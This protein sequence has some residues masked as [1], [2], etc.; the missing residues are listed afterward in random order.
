MS[1]EK[2]GE[3]QKKPDGAQDNS[4]SSSEQNAAGD[5][6][7]GVPSA[8]DLATS[9]PVQP[10]QSNDTSNSGASGASPPAS[11]TGSANAGSTN[12]SAP[13]NASTSASPSTPVN[14]E[15]DD[16]YVPPPPTYADLAARNLPAVIKDANNTTQANQSSTNQTGSSGSSGPSTIPA[17]SGIPGGVP[18]GVKQDKFAVDEVVSFGWKAMLKYFWPLTGVFTC[19]FMVQMVPTVTTLVLKYCVAQTAAISLVSAVVSLL[20]AVVSLIMSVGVINMWLKIVDGDSIAVRDVYSKW[21]RTWNFMLAS[22]VYGV[23]VIAG[24]IC[25]IIPGIYLQ[26][27]FQFYPFFIVESNAGPITSL[28]ASWAISRGALAELFF[29]GIVSY[30]INWIGMLCL[31]VGMYPAFIVQSLALAKT[32]RM[33]RKNTP[34]NEMP[35]NLMPLALISDSEPPPQPV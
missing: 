29:F 3:E 26:M 35:L 22:I 5:Y 28:K 4:A 13:S 6:V 23:M 2:P 33:L 10:A 17:V 1:D 15:D 31:L 7:F 19:N 11:A 14:P 9:E 32:Y 34:L 18:V 21:S 30:F 24:Y 20:G 16:N 12:A 8:M 27:R 25:L